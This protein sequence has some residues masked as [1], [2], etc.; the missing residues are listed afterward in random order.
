[1]G[2]FKTQTVLVSLSSGLLVSYSFFKCFI[3]TNCMQIPLVFFRLVDHDSHANLY[4][5]G[6]SSHRNG[7]LHRSNPRKSL[8]CGPL[9]AL[10]K[11]NHRQGRGIRGRW[12]FAIQETN[13]LHPH[14]PSVRS[15]F[16]GSRSHGFWSRKSPFGPKQS[17]P[18]RTVHLQSALP[19]GFSTP[20]VWKLPNTRI[21]LLLTPWENKH[22]LF[23]GWSVG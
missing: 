9:S 5:F 2:K 13:P 21:R 6:H 16:H 12:R 19:L 22:P 23:Y 17:L 18:G 14:G 7:L 15:N 11:F 8:H 3:L 1:M 4:N 20:K 10:C